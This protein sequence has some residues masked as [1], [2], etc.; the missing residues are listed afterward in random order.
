MK[1]SFVFTDYYRNVVT[2]SFQDHPF[3]THPKHV[4]VICRFHD[5]WLL[6]K[7]P[8]RGWEFPGGKVEPGETAEEAARREVYEETGAIVAELAYIGQYKVEGKSGS[9][10]KNV[11]F[12]TID[13]IE[14]KAHYL[15]TNG[16]LFLEEIP[17]NIKDNPKFSFMMRD[18]V[19]SLSLQ[20]IRKYRPLS[21]PQK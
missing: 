14:Q 3:S 5:Q 7:H 1:S 15:E 12:A 19:L 13:R 20:Y 8:R 6:T 9:I 4:W 17:R 21:Q 18:D 16:P 10:I 11:Y 2:Y